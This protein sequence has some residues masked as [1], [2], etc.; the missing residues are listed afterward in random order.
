MNG[1]IYA[2]MHTHSE[3][4]HDST[5]PIEEMLEAQLKNGTNIFAVTDHC[6]LL[7]Y[8]KIDVFTPILKSCR[9]V[10]ELREKTGAEILTGI[11][12]CESFW[13]PEQHQ[14]ALSLFDF[15]VVIGSVH[16]VLYGDNPIPYSHIDFSTYTNEEINKYLTCY[17]NDMK[18]M[19]ETTDFDVLAHLTCPLR[20][21]Q[22]K[23]GR[24]VD[25]SPYLCQIEEILHL[26]IKRGISLEINSS[27]L[28]DYNLL[29]PEESILKI[30]KNMDGKLLTY[31]SDA[32]TSQNA[33]NNI[34]QVHEIAKKLG[35]NGLYYYKKRKP[36][37]YEI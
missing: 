3:F 16:T 31:G 17:F 36:I 34:E 35:F 14:K 21:I 5:C 13:Y 8:E 4:S 28:T 30:Y 19:V 10:M 22:G 15:D 25:L 37:K 27:S 32:H 24:K 11:E 23:Y 20:Y 12:T 2:D 26:I 33:S 9:K 7:F 29:M 6:D 18:K 1:K